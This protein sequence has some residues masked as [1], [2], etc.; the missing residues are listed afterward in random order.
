MARRLMFIIALLWV[1]LAT[2]P[3]AA[4][5]VATFWSHDQDDDFPHTFFALKGAPDAGGP[6]LDINYGFTARTSTPAILWSTVDGAVQSRERAYLKRSDA[7]FSV[8]VNDAQ[9]AALMALVAEWRADPR[10]NLNKRNCV[11]FIAEALRR[12]G[13]TVPDLPKLMKKPK[14][15]LVAV[16]QANGTR[17]TQIRLDGKAYF[18]KYDPAEEP[19]PASVR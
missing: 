9:F 8:E 17:V 18:A 11:H 1:G 5:V 16:G 3:A 19:L 7:Q 14:S 13:L 10:Y 4:A 6:A 12:V 2:Q 15:F